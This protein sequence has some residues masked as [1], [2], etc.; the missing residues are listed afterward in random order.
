MSGMSTKMHLIA[1]RTGSFQGVSA[2]I[3]GKGFADMYF[4]VKSVPA[5]DFDKWVSFVKQ[6]RTS[7]DFGAY[8]RLANPTIDSTISYYSHVSPDLYHQVVDKYN[9]VG[10]VQL[11]GSI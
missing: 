5:A 7:L 6:N 4:T 8:Q 1:D 9:R 3:S 2:N 11:E 10:G